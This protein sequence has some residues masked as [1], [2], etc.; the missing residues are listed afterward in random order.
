MTR[1]SSEMAGK[2]FLQ[3][4]GCLRTESISKDLVF[5]RCIALLSSLHYS[6]STNRIEACGLGLKV[7]VYL[8]SFQKQEP[9][10]VW[11][12][13]ARSS[14]VGTRKSCRNLLSQHGSAEFP[15]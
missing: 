14:P 2:S 13:S 11:N 15:S 12:R 5:W 8:Y 3:P 10:Y 6:S 9:R 7:D 1:D 4:L